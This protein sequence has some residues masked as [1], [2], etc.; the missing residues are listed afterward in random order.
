LGIRVS[1]RDLGLLREGLL[2]G[3]R[4]LPESV[5]DG[6]ETYHVGSL[7]GLDARQT[8]RDGE[9][10]RRRWVRVL[11]QG[12]TEVRLI[13]QGATVEEFEYWLPMFFT[14]MR[15]FRFGDWWTEVTGR[16]WVESLDARARPDNAAPDDSISNDIGPT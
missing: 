10:L 7:V 2:A 15:T 1:R 5:V 6:L 9:V 3:M 12:S 14:T 16:E 8:Y 4:Q 11:Y 13:A